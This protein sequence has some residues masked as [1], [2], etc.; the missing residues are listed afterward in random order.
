MRDA[1][2]RTRM[3]APNQTSETIEVQGVSVPR[4]GKDDRTIGPDEG[5]DRD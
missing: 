1:G 2:R 4:L 5:P 3:T